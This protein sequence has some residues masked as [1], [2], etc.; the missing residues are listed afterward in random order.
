MFR[1]RPFN[2]KT[3]G[4]RIGDHAGHLIKELIF[5]ELQVSEMDQL[6]EKA[7][8]AYN[9]IMNLEKGNHE[10]ERIE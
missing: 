6:R 8:D 3:L 4:K 7:L 10:M 5:A 1:E 9:F 2:A